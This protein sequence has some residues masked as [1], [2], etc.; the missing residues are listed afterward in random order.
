MLK[1][2][3]RSTQRAT[4]SEGIPPNSVT[5]QTDGPQ[6]R[7][8][9]RPNGKVLTVFA[10]L[11]VLGFLIVR[12]LRSGEVAHAEVQTA[13]VTRGDVR[14]TVSASGKLQAFTTV[15]VKS[16]AGGTVLKMAV[17]EGTRV[18]TGQL[19]ATIDQQDTTAAYRQAV[20]DVD[21][22][23]A[24]LRQAQ[25]SAR[26]QQQTTGPAI[27]QSAEAVSAAQAAL[28]QARENLA[29]ESGTLEP[30]IRQAQETV[31]SARAKLQ[32]AQEA[33]ALQRRTSET[34]IVQ[35]RG[36]VASAQ[37]RL[38]AAQET[39]KA[40]PSLSEASVAQAQA[41]VEAAQAAVQSAQE[42][43]R[44]LQ[45]ATQP[46]ERASVQAQVEQ[47]QSN[48]K[49]AQTNLQRQEQLLT[50]GFVAQN[51]V[52]TAR[53]T[54]ETAQASLN[55]AQARL[56]TLKEQQAAEVRQSQAQV[57]NARGQ[58]SQ[59]QAALNSARAN[60]VQNRIKNQDVT[61]ARAEVQQ[62]Q[63]QL[64]DALA[65]R[66]QIAVKQAD[67]TSAQ[68]ATRQA[69]AALASTRAGGRQVNV[70]AAG[71]QSAQAQVRQAQAALRSSQANTL[72][73]NVKKEDVAKAQAQLARAEVTAQNART[74]LSQTR[75]VAPRDGIVLTKYVD[76]G[77][78]IQSGQSGFS[79]GTSIVQLADI[80]RVYVDTEVDEAD[81]AQIKTGQSVS[82]T[83][84]A[85]PESPLAGMV[86]KVYPKAEEE[87]NVTYVHVQVEVA[88]KDVSAR[89]RPGMNA[90]CEF[91]TGERRNVLNVPADAVKDENGKATVTLIK[92]P[93]QPLW[94]EHNQEKR[95]VQT[96]MHGD[97]ATEIIG[98]LQEGETVVTKIVQPATGLSGAGGRSGI[99]MGGG[100]PPR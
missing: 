32:Q 46:Q 67:V 43:L 62:A 96:G 68:A 8:F 70:R 45:S 76:E 52:D 17:E 27:A 22:A 34:S 24:T 2:P 25:E 74:N 21:A 64:E 10:V 16:K 48:L 50:K 39:A 37:A 36:V 13:K 95:A 18:K 7:R 60:T 65:N 15:D 14:Q 89:L 20:A 82:I 61:A 100:P 19:I 40:Q 87:S 12:Y 30:N 33:L 35:A 80:S 28:K 41:S 98:G 83:L 69:E 86:R 93:R 88:A 78:I 51:V 79:G 5:S 94:N 47:A 29:L 6:R 84:D 59:S 9:K 66:R 31:A 4:E 85:Y 75:V 11:G 55:T 26:L 49:V 99:G 73:N 3:F 77:T 72:Q 44:L 54:V 63:A 56:N 23:R 92:D 91:L 58:L 90:T 97:D 53:N 57:E 1:L 71:V 81:I 38:A 42:N